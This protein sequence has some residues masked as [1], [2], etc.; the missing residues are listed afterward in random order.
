MF[1]KILI[2][3]RGEIAV[4]LIRACS[5]LDI[6]SV[7][8]YSDADRHAL[9]VKKA[10]ESYNVG[11]DPLAGYL[12]AHNI[13]NIAVTS[14][15]DAIHPG[16]GFLS[17]N[18]ELAEICARRDIKFI[19]PNADIIRQMGDKIQARTAMISAAI[20]VI[21]GSEGNI[22]SLDEAK[23]LAS[24]IGYPIMLKATNGG[25]GRGIRRCNNEKELIANYDRVISEATKAFG[26]PEVFIEKCIVSPKHIEV[27]IL[28]DSSGNVVHL[29]ERDCSI[30]RRNQKLIEIA[31][32]PQ[33]TNAQ[34]NYV[35]EL[36]VKAAK[37]VNYENAGTV[38]FLLDAEN[39]FYFM[40]MNTRLQVEHT[41]TESITGIDIV[42]EQI[43]IAFGLSLQYKQEEIQFRGFAIEYRINAED[44]KYD[45]MPS[46]GK[47]TRYYAPGGP[48]V[49]IDASIY[50]GYVIPPYYD[51]MCAKLTVWALNWESVM[52]R[53]KRALNDIVVFGVKTTIPYYLEI[54]NNKQF[55]EANFN[56]SF[57]DDHPELI[58]YQ[59]QFPPE[60]M[61]AAIS[62]AIAAHEGI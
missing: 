6:T 37:A 45:F 19:G 1:K 62:A 30:Q 11:A 10:D 12:N 16:Y 60:L 42:Q 4:R 36:A 32:S 54:M 34:R 48:G 17:E 41:I 25:G 53:G 38:E 44:P 14:G 23:K 52:Q 39:N 13:V 20:P 43:R 51:S 59:S 35:G 58:N 8:I 3:N 18:P 31:P 47:I 40:E 46:F 50:T 33:L 56:T 7:A 61:A 49:R 26:K 55:K 15:C 27:Q 24:S 29:F 57:V 28:A 5:E 9:H 22:E 2:A 21:P